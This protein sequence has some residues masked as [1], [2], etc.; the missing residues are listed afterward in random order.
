[1]LSRRLKGLKAYKTETTSAPVR[2]SS[3]ELPF[4]PPESLKKSVTSR[5]KSLNPSLYPDPNCTELKEVLSEFLGVP[6]ENMM[7]GNG[8]DELIYYLSAVAGE[9]SEGVLVTEPTFPMYGIS[10]QVMGRP[11]VSTLLDENFDIDLPSCLESVSA[12]AVSLAFFAYPNNPTGNLYSREKIQKIRDEGIFTVIDE[13]YYHYSGESF[14]DEA[15]KR[16]DTVVLRSLSKIGMA[17]L[18]IGV[19]IGA[20]E[21]VSELEKVR[22]PF[23]ITLPSQVMAVVMLTEGRDFIEESIEKV[24]KE[25]ERLS[26]EMAGIEGVQVFP[27][28]ANFILFKTLFDASLLHGEILKGGVLVRDVSYMPLLE[29]CLRVSVGKPEE[30]DRFLEALNG[31]MKSLQ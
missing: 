29:G 5:I 7:L 6:P 26:R 20:K 16:S 25:R 17:G 12:G 31:A 30:N 23:N 19:L 15:L 3:N 14:M 9:P 18:R 13:A 2:L 4:E 11:V 24:I 28:R 10:A 21:V 8:S 27:S 22:L 1:M